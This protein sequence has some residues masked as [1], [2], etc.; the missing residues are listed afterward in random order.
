MIIK[1]PDLSIIEHLKQKN[2]WEHFSN[3]FFTLEKTKDDG[4]EIV[5]K[6]KINKEE[7]EK[8]LKELEKEISELKKLIE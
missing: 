3:Y 5:F 7:V 1:Q 4:N 2:G 6:L 8:T